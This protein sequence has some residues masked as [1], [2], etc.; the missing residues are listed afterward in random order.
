MRPASPAPSCEFRIKLAERLIDDQQL[1]AQKP[2]VDYGDLPSQPSPEDFFLLSRV[3][4]VVSVGKLCMTSGLG[5]DKT[6]AAIERLLNVGLLHAVDESGKPIKNSAPPKPE[7][8]SH[9]SHDAAE[10]SPRPPQFN[11]PPSL[12]FAVDGTGDA[13]SEPSTGDLMN[14]GGPDMASLDDDDDDL[15][16]ASSP[17]HKARVEGHHPPS[18]TGGRERPKTSPGGGRPSS[19]ASVGG[20][21]LAKKREPAKE[22]RRFERFPSSFDEY[23]PDPSLM[24][25]GIDDELQREIHF[26]YESLDEID[27]YQLFGVAE[28]ADR[29]VIRKSYFTLSKR[30]HPD[31]FFREEAGEV[32]SRVDSIFKFV[33]KG[34]QTLSKKDK[35]AE[36]DR[37]LAQSRA[38]ADQASADDEKKRSMAAD[39]L[40]RR[41]GQLEEQGKLLEAAGELRKVASLRRDPY[42]LLRAATLLLR[43]NQSLDE[44]ASFARAA[45]MELPDE[46]QPRLVLGQ[47]YEKNNMLKEANDAL[48]EAVSIAP[49]DPSVRVHLE[50]VRSRLE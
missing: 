26:V 8:R 28:D 21:P 47:I 1:L 42:V 46:P 2:D 45:A 13:L 43:A 36:Y 19:S 4:G 18:A 25:E 22:A 29:K 41:A 35:R 44:A 10:V 27:F 31:K 17:A 33:T 15:F 14:R 20:M 30:F 5:R 34:Y 50:R 12:E 7:V 11:E 32:A 39:M 24:V 3:N 48:E 40:E 38:E 23:R 49:D 9:S 16:M 37:A 6:I